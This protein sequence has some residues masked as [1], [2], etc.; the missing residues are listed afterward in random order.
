M[1]TPI[2]I[3]SH[4][5]LFYLFSHT[6][7]CVRNLLLSVEVTVTDIDVQYANQKRLIMTE[8]TINPVSV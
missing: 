8:L 5:S 3:V 2:Q 4:E 7:I 6:G 1:H